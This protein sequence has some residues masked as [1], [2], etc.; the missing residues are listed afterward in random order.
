MC[1]FDSD[2]FKYYFAIQ[3]EKWFFKKLI[4]KDF[5]NFHMPSACSISKTPMQFQLTFPR[6]GYS[7]PS[8]MIILI[9]C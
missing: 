9:R 1:M 5:F 4:L 6:F 7:D 3:L 2:D 8:L